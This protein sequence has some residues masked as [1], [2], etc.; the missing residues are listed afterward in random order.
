MMTGTAWNV[1]EEHRSSVPGLGVRSALTT[2]FLLTVGVL[3]EDLTFP[4]ELVLSG[5]RGIVGGRGL[6]G[7]FSSLGYFLYWLSTFFLIS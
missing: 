3:G 5:G 2:I 1:P 6:G 4:S 7:V